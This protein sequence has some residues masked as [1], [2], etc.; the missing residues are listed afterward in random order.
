VGRYSP[1]LSRSHK[2]Q[3]LCRDCYRLSWTVDRY[4]SGSRLRFPTRYT[5]DTD[6][7]G[8]RR[9]AKKWGAAM[10]PEKETWCGS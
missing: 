9:F 6:E 4:Y 7:A 10:P 1:N 3:R 8:A 5:R 2:I